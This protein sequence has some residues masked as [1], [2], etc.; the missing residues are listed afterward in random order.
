[1]ISVSFNFWISIWRLTYTS[2]Q[3]LVGASYTDVHAQLP[4]NIV[5]VA[6]SIAF[7]IVLFATA[8]SRKWKAPV[9][10]LGI[11]AL[12]GIVLASICLPCRPHHT[13]RIARPHRQLECRQAL[14][15]RRDAEAPAD[16]A[17]SEAAAKRANAATS[18]AE[19]L[20][21]S[22]VRG[23]FAAADDCPCT[24]LEDTDRYHVMAI[25]SRSGL[26]REIDTT[27]SKGRRG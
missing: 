1:M 21:P 8:S 17:V 2:R 7:A 26:A 23:L 14:T 9:V 13:H 19:D 24:P 18:D 10:M 3:Q 12:A 16:E 22:S 11:W 4:A 25:W 27:V 20:T 6:L 5:M 15:D